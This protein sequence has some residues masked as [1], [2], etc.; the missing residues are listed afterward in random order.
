MR[1]RPVERVLEETLYEIAPRNWE[2]LVVMSQRFAA[3]HPLVSSSDVG[4][5]YERER[6]VSREFRAY[7]IIFAV[8]YGIG[9]SIVD[10]FV[11]SESQKMF[12]KLAVTVTSLLIMTFLE[13]IR[14]FWYTLLFGIYVNFPRYRGGTK[15]K[16]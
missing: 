3:I 11:T 14:D 13:A 15:F 5:Q 10:S 4:V 12:A 6:L 16:R 8:C 1:V 2:R 7:F 9:F